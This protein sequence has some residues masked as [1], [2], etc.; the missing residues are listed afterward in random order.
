[1]LR[2]AYALVDSGNASGTEVDDDA[3]RA[4]QQEHSFVESLVAAGE[5]SKREQVE[6]T[7]AQEIELDKL[8][9]G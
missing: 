6:L 3:R 8:F 2:I 7:Q 5:L 9:L 1:M 4:L